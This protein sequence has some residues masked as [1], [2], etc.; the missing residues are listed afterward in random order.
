MAV[1]SFTHP[2]FLFFLFAVPLIFFI[3]FFSLSNRKKVALKFANFQAISKIQG[4]DFFSK[5]IVML[6]LTL[7]VVVFLIFAVSG[8]TLHTTKQAS[9]FSFVIAIDSSKSMEADDFFPNRLEASKQIAIDFVDS[10]PYG[11]NIG[12]I[13]FSGSSLI[14]L[15]LTQDKEMVKN[16]IEVIDFSGFGGTDVYDA[17][18]T[19]SNL[20]EGEDSKAV[21]LLS[22]GQINVGRGDEA[23]YHAEINDVIFH[24][25]AI[26]TLEGGATSNAISKVDE[27]YLKSLAYNT[28]GE[29]FF[30]ENEV[31]LSESLFEILDLTEKRVSISLSSYLIIFA[32]ILYTIGYFLNNTRYLNLP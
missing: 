11:G 2:Q 20:L 18:V 28:G 19:S 10:I 30:A 6:F 4:V 21:I 13:S 3:H 7:I 8:L 9:S 12:V 15:A 25:I 23:V 31:A 14:E 26:G 32:I 5:N 17:V 24:T 27:E 29:Y 1:F 16:A 22:D